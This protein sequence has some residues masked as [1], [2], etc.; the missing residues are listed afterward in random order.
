M[1]DKNKNR[2]NNV[3]KRKRKNRI[4]KEKKCVHY[5]NKRQKILNSKEYVRTKKEKNQD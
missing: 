5:N 1:T 2:S 3:M 4:R